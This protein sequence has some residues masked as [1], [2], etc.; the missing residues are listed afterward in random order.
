[1][2]LLEIYRTQNRQRVPRRPFLAKHQIAIFASILVLTTIHCRFVQAEPVKPSVPLMKLS[3]NEEKSKSPLYIKSET[4]TLDTKNHTFTYEGKVEMWQ[5]D[6]S[7]TGEKVIG[8][9]GDDNKIQTITCQKNV[10]ITRGA[11]L[12]ASSEFALYN[13][14]TGVIEL[15]E[16]PELLN[17]GNAL[18]ADKVLIYL[19]EDR[20]EAQGNVRVK[21]IRPENPEDVSGEAA[22]DGLKKLVE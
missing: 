13:V 4:L 22:G 18:T 3:L 16:G 20:S 10:V 19:N 5:D 7:V 14:E 11:T 6:L 1:M 15:T 2:E 8:R 9:Y 17:N 21:V 12:R